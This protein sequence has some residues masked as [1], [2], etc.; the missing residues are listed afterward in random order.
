M[1]RILILTFLLVIMA[2]CQESGSENDELPNIILILVDDMGWTGR[3]EYDNG[4][5][6]VWPDWF[7]KGELRPEPRRKTF[8]S[9][10]HN[11]KD[12]PLIE[13]G[14][15]GPVMLRPVQVLPVK[16]PHP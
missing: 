7:V 16:F 4:T 10:G 6:T 5:L 2:S 12:T 9:W 8:T 3:D 1:I 11:R 15:L 14:L 13:S